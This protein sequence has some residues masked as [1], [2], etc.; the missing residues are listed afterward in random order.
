MTNRIKFLIAAFVLTTGIAYAQPDDGSLGSEEVE[1]VKNF[2]AKL[3]EAEKL[4]IPPV[5]PELNAEI[6]P[7]QYFIATKDLAVDY[8]APRIR[9]LSM[10]GEELPDNYKGYVKFGGGLPLG[11][12]AEAG[13]FTYDKSENFRLGL[14]FDH[15]NANND[16]NVEN[17]RFANTGA[18]LKGAY[19]ADE[20]FAVESNLG[21]RRDVFHFYGYNFDGSG[22]EN[23]L[24][25]NVR[26][27]FNTFDFDATVFNSARTVA[28]FDY[29]A[30]VEFYNRNDNYGARENAFALN[31]GGA[32][33]LNDQHE[34]SLDIISDFTNYRDTTEQSLNNFYLQPAFTF[35]H[36]RFKIKAGVNVVWHENEAFI[37]PNATA[38]ANIID[39]RLQGFLGAEG[40]LDKNSF[41]KLT[42]Y[43]P[44]ILTRFPAFQLENTRVNHYFGGVK[45]A[46][47]IFDYQAQL[48]YQDAENLP[49]YLTD[50]DARTAARRFDVLFDNVNTWNFQASATAAV[51]SN[52]EVLAA[53][54]TNVYDLETQEKAWG[55]PAVTINGAVIHTT[56]DDK[57]QLRG[58]LFLQD[59]IPFQEDDGTVVTLNRLLDVS[60]GAEYAVNKNFG[61]WLRLNNIANSRYERW[62]NYPTLGINVLA[63]IAAK[64]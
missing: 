36:E 50:P 55:L 4:S 33:W 60:L 3:M 32:K 35:H 62:Q 42:D 22:L 23:V 64:F 13:Y 34:L 16:A 9:P 59:G 20:G 61:A 21:F 46:F 39:T 14:D 1:V 11:L 30:G 10:R 53:V 48:G 27:E 8:D 58:D 17:Q 26:Q 18:H 43:N 51:L 5:L 24:Q 7:Q 57:L 41:R 45:G 38:E 44:Y 52:L 2:E 15:Y 37:F 31:L 28:D 40:T 47:S 56:L 6:Q 12:F 54:N 25:E 49:L 63:G 19:Y 29:K